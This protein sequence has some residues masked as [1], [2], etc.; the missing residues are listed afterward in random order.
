MTQQSLEGI[1]P[2]WKPEGFTSH[3]VVAKARGILG[4]KR[5]GH[6]GTL[7]PQVTGV[8]PLCIGRA[9]RMV[10][11]MQELPKEYEAKLLVGLSTDTEDMTGTVTAEVPHVHLEESQVRDILHR[12]VGDI[13]QTPPMFSAVKVDGKRLYE[14]AR[15]GKEVERK[16]RRVTIHRLDIVRMDLTAERPE[17]HFR[18]LCSK[19]TYIRTLCVDIGK[20]LGYPAVMKSLIRTSTGS[21]RKEQ[22]LTFEQIAELKKQGDLQNHLIPMDQAISHIPAVELSAQE[23]VHVQQGKRIALPAQRVESAKDSQVLV[24]A[25]S[26]D[27]RF[28]GLFEWRSAGQI[29]IPSK[30]FH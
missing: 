8:L 3:D 22:C 28:L 17:I 10:E 26:P 16:S 24:R 7:D 14:L 21:I 12:F 25:Y 9:T 27:Q 5:I 18:V 15:E 23:A 30:V 2:V 13:D 19:G 6:T 20:A 29:L 4:I 1:L 11:Y